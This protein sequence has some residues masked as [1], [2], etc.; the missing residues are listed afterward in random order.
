M[1]S[2]RLL[3]AFLL[4]APSAARAD[5]LIYRFGNWYRIPG[6]GSD[7]EGDGGSTVGRI[8]RPP[9]GDETAPDRGDGSVYDLGTDAPDAAEPRVDAPGDGA[10]GESLRAARAREETIAR[11]STSP[12][13]REVVRFEGYAPGTIVI[14][15]TKKRLFLVLD[16][17]ASALQYGVG[18]G[19]EGFSWKG[20]ETISAKREWPDWTPPA[21]M[22]ARDPKLPVHMDG[23]LENPLGARALYLGET[24]YRIHGTNQPSSIGKSVSSGCIRLAN[25]DIIDL[26]ERVTIG[27]TVVVS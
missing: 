12:I 17:G 19:R 16:D 26:Y 21:E 11:A 13:R 25:A 20:T 5:T 15:T 1:I 27:A 6:P 9:R 3:L 22:R 10:D 4:A 8:R 24:L 7:D 2:R 18:V 23:G 14:S